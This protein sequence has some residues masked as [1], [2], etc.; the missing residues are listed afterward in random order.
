LHYTGLI[1]AFGLLFN[2]F[3]AIILVGIYH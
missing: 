1:L 3:R 2:L